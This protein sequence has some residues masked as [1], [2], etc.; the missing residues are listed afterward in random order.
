MRTLDQ[1]A[2]N[3]GQTVHIYYDE[4]TQEYA[5]FKLF[6]ERPDNPPKD[7]PPEAPDE[8]GD[9]ESAGSSAK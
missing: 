7:D 9:P 8:S 1:L 3:T 2:R 5:G 6:S 4:Q